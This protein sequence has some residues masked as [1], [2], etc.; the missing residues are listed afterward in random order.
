MPSSFQTDDGENGAD[1][2]RR[3]TLEA[4]STTVGD[5]LYAGNR[6][7]AR[8]LDRT[9]RGIDFQGRRF[10]PYS[11]RGPYY[12]YPG[13]RSQNRGASRGVRWRST[14]RVGRKTRLGIK[15]DNYG[16]FKRAIGRSHVDLRGANTPHML[17]AIVVMS[18]GVKVG[19]RRQIPLRGFNRPGK[20][21][22]VGIYGNEAERAE[23]HNEGAGNL[24]RRRFFDVSDSDLNMI[25]QDITDRQEQRMMRRR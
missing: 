9:A 3:I 2:I 15:Y 6:Q 14:G 21:L 22:A 18:D 10:A 7:K 20:R 11:T 16:A 23:G 12:S 24:P 25:M 17:Q 4:E 8:I 5:L 13:K 1:F 19:E